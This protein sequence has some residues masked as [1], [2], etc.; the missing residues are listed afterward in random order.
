MPDATATAPP[1]L[2]ATERAPLPASS[3]PPVVFLHGLGCERG[4]YIRQW[5]GLNPELWLL[6]LDLPGHGDSP[7]SPTG[8]YTVRSMTD[9]V[10]GELRG[11]GLKGVVLV[12]HSAGG[13]IA[14]NLALTSPDLVGGIVALD[15]TIVLTAEHRQQNR[16]RAAESEK[17]DWRQYHMA[18]MRD[19]W[20][21]DGDDPLRVQVLSTLERTP[22]HVVRPFWHDILAF[23]PENA[24]RRCPVPMLYVRSR[25]DTDLEILRSLNPL[26]SVEDLRPHCQG[27]WPHLQ[28]PGPVNDIL[29]EFVAGLSEDARWISQS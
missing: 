11:R 3:R 10:A 24:C 13:L 26:I 5:H 8:T 12:G 16:R 27:H 23:D 2:A 20:G 15:T 6:S 9:A 25:R 17:G 14:L 29:Q 22:E 4:Q 19:S 7:R 1:R 21:P 18:S 28:C